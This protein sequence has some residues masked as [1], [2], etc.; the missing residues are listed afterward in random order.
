[1]VLYRDFVCRNAKSLGLVGEVR[2]LP[3]GT[4]RVIAEGPR[5]AL[6]KLIVRL[7]KGSL[8]AHVREVEVTWRSMLGTFTA[9]NITY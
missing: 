3:D 6:L 4:V 5:D 9:F 1:M 7:H 2:N 8:L